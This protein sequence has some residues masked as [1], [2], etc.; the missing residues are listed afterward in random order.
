M[1]VRRWFSARRAE[2]RAVAEYRDAWRA[3]RALRES[4][5]HRPD[6]SPEDSHD[7]NVPFAQKPGT[8]P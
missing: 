1:P 8:T 2:R 6:R 7:G 4:R 5:A 3:L